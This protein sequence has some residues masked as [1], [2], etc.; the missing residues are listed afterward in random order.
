M[1]NYHSLQA[2]VK[3]Q[4]VHNSLVAANYTWS[5]ALTNANAD[6][7]GA[8]QISTN[9]AAEYGPSAA[10]RRHMFNFNAV[11]A[12]PSFMSSMASSAVCLGVGRSPVSAA[13]I[14]VY[15]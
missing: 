12:L 10:D 7:S 5:H 6:R 13:S 9:T 14:R 11:Y 4:W 3:K 1:G 15:R 8:P 2:S